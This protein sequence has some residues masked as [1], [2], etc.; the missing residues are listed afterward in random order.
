MNPA[1]GKAPTPIPNLIIDRYRCTIK[2]WDHEKQDYHEMSKELI[3]DLHLF[4][5]SKKEYPNIT[6]I[7]K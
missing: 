7:K 6:Y 2:V 3:D 5:H 1:T 4:I